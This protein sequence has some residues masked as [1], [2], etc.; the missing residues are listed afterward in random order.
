[1]A[2]KVSRC[3]QVNALEGTNSDR[4]PALLVRKKRPFPRDFY[5]PIVSLNLTLHRLHN[6][7]HA[8]AYLVTDTLEDAAQRS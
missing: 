4:L 8:D 5:V 3:C 7:Q 1:M 6:L 2:F